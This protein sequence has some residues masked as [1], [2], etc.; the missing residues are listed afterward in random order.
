MEKIII[1]LYDHSGIAV[2]PWA[3]EGYTVLLFDELHDNGLNVVNRYGYDMYAV[4]VKFDDTDN[5]KNIT[6]ITDYVNILG[7][8]SNVSI[9]IGFPPCTHLA[10]SGNRWRK[11][12]LE[13]DPFIIDKAMNLV[14]LVKMAGEYFNCA[15]ALENPVG[16]IPTKWR[17]SDFFV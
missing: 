15:W 2:L 1:S 14:Y 10:V 13:K 7:G 8:T 4:G 5:D 6:T 12:K 17:K 3:R 11:K 9:V 16:I